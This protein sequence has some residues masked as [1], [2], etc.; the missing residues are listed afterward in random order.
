MEIEQV[1][2]CDIVPYENNPR[3]ND[4]AVGIVA[5][6]IKE[7]G[8]LVP[9]ILD[10]K[11]Y[12][13]AGHTR[14]K[15]A[16]KLGMSQVPCIYAE[17]LTDAQIKAFRIMDNKSN[18]YSMWDEVLLKSEF[19]F[20]KDKIN[21]TLTGFTEAEQERILNPD[22]KLIDGKKDAKYQIKIG[23]CFQI[24][25]HRIICGDS[26]KPETYKKL[27]GENKIHLV[28]TDPP[29]GVSYKGMA[30]QGR[31]NMD[32]G[33]NRVWEEIENDDLRGED[34][35]KLIKDSFKE[36][37]PYLISNAALYV[38]HSS[39]NQM[40]FE[41][42][43]NEAGYEVKQQLI[44]QKHHVLSH[45]HYHWCHEPMF[46]CQK[47]GQSPSFYGTKTNRTTLNNLEPTKMNIGEL[48]KFVQT[49]QEES[50]IWA[51][52]KDAASDY[53]HPTQKPIQLAERALINSSQPEENV[54]DMYGGSG[55]TLLACENKNRNAFIVEL[56]P[57]F[58]SH[59]IE[60]WE[61]ATGNKAIPDTK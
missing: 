12:I 9:I 29:Y 5:K 35:Y 50:T 42:A 15:A 10:D 3:K 4:K 53:I 24:G 34:L 41:K 43:L 37:N 30:N 33:N 26:T 7:F 8:F 51:I 36:I 20:L 52:S 55:S 49:L 48:M 2:I 19:E 56:D 13:V 46:Y 45:A 16:I 60:R 21:L 61:D 22:G 23:D 58:C 57:V 27:I 14:L 6:S 1:N 44:W 17:G 32:R 39:S 40:I 31:R 18:Q 59:I 11:N 47:I 25:R 28:F 38:F 54:L